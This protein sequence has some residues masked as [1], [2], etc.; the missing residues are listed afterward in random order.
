[1]RSSLAVPKRG[2]SG[3]L[4]YAGELDDEGRGVVVAANVAGAATLVATANREAPKQALRDGVA[5]FLVNS[6]DEALRILKNVLRK[7]E[8]AAV[9][10]ALAP[11]AVEREMQ[12]RGVAPDLLRTDATIGAGDDRGRRGEAVQESGTKDPAFLTWRVASTLPKELARLDEIALECLGAE[13]WAARRWLRQAPRFLGR[14]AE[15]Y[16]LLECD[17]AFAMRFAEEVRMRMK[18]G[19]IEVAVE[20]RTEFADGHED[21]RLVPEE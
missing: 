16:R 10:V 20:I 21:H 18:R 13:D 5:D 4:F 7:G 8:T 9:C 3:K 2:L 11:D 1:M 12:E 14:M 6:L 15:G 19:Q 17:R